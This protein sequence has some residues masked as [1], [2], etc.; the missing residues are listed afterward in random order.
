MQSH[1]GR[2]G[3]TVLVVEDEARMLRLL[4]IMLTAENISVLLA[5]NGEEA[6]D[7][8]RNHKCDISVI[9]LDLRLP[10][11][12]G[13]DVLETVKRE[14]PDVCVVIAS[15]YVD[16]NVKSRMQ[17]SGVKHFIDKP[18]N[19]QQLLETLQSAIKD[20]CAMHSSP[21]SNED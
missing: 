13:Y 11:I 1:D 4:E 12:S 2:Y 17:Q 9:L 18:Y 14:D 16:E 15:G 20:R 10:K 8:Y 5:A 3:S 21:S 6:L 19:C 7:L